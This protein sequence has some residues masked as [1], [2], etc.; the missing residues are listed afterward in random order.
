MDTKTNF[1]KFSCRLSNDDVTLLAKQNGLTAPQENMVRAMMADFVQRVK[2]HVYYKQ[3]KENQIQAAMTLGEACDSWCES[4]LDADELWKGYMADQIAMRGLM[5]GYEV[6][7]K[8]LEKQYGTEVSQLHFW[9][10]EREDVS[11]A[12]AMAVL[13]QKEITVLDSGQMNPLKSVLFSI[14]IS[15]DE[16]GYVPQGHLER[17]LCN[18]CGNVNCPN[19][20]T[21]E[22]R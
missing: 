12:D 8:V 16:S 19:R 3:T 2:I 14:D 21:D 4:F 20:I 17:G 22:K 7:R 9:D 10:G 1:L 18:A 6:F 15:R 13:M 5:S 11:I